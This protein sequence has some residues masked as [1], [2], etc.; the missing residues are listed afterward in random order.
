MECHTK[1]HNQGH[2]HKDNLLLDF[3]NY[4]AN[5]GYIYPKNHPL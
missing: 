1:D 3:S 5:Q 4:Q 2:H